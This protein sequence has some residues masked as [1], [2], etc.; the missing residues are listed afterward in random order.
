MPKRPCIVCGVLT[1]ATRCPTHQRPTTAQR[2][3]GYRHQA[4]RDK[5][6]PTVE[7]GNVECWRCGQLIDPQAPWDLG[8]DDRDRTLHRGPEHLHCNRATNRSR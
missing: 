1:P 2:G 3:Y 5:W 6:K 4:E 7:Q 8:H